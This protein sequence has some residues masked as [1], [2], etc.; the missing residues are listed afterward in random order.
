MKTYIWFDVTWNSNFHG[1]PH[2]PDLSRSKLTCFPQDGQDVPYSETRIHI[3][4]QDSKEETRTWRLI[5]RVG[6]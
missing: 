4:R 6:F 1:S 5:N 3:K 2:D